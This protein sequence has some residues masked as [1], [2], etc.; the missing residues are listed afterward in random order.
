[1]TIEEA[2]N[3]AE[4]WE[5]EFDEK[6]P[7]LLLAFPADSI[8]RTFDEGKVEVTQNIKAFIQKTRQEAWTDGYSLGVHHSEEECRIDCDEAV[9]EAIA[10]ERKRI[11]ALL[12]KEE[13]VHG[14]QP[15]GY[16]E[17]AKEEEIYFTGF[18]DG[19]GLLKID[20]LNLLTSSP[21][22]SKES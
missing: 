5:K 7:K 9:Q 16:C 19:R 14:F 3:K 10:G 2:I 4:E 18:K 12:Q 11:K 8:D 22:T 17:E 1:M 6:Y 13:T 20:L 21:N 15:F